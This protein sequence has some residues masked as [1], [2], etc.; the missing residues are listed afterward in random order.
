MFGIV[1]VYAFA[2]A[3][4]LPGFALVVIDAAAAVLESLL[5]EEAVGAGQG[6]IQVASAAIIVADLFAL[7][8][9][10]KPAVWAVGVFVAATGLA[11]WIEA[12]RTV[13]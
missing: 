4:V 9:A 11:G 12:N 10:A 6:A 8:I 3:A 5:V 7:V 13:L 2:V 1:R